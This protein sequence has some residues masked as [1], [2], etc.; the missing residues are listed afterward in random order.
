MKLH[1]FARLA[2]RCAILCLPALV[3]TLICGGATSAQQPAGAGTH[4][5]SLPDSPQPKQQVEENSQGGT[6]KFVGYLTKRSLF[7][8]DIAATSTPLSTGDKFKLFV[9]EGI[10]PATVVTSVV[11]AGF[12]Q[13]RDVPH[14]YGQGAEGY[15]KRFGASM[16]R[17]ATASFFGTFLISSALHDDPRFY[18]QIHPTLWGSVKYSAKRLVVTRSDAGESVVNAAGLIGPLG[19]EALANVYLPRS[20]QTGAKTLERY[21]SDLGWRFASNMFK[22]YWPTF[23]RELGLRRLGVIPTPATTQPMEQ[24]KGAR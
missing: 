7:F 9:N 11:S 5:T 24:R 21:G 4:G 20:E 23:F 10:S 2:K 22:N 3:F 15:G 19:A 6:A 18:P 13:A 12:G 8:P 17:G 14:D 16:A 1:P